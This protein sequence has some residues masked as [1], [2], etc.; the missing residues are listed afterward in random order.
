M[1]I[2]IE[3]FLNNKK[4]SSSTTEVVEEEKKYGKIYLVKVATGLGKTKEIEAADVPLIACPTNDLKRELYDRRVASGKEVVMTPDSVKFSDERLDEKVQILYILDDY[5]AVRHIIQSI[6]KYGAYEHYRVTTDDRESCILY[7]DQNKQIK[8]NK[9]KTIITTHKRVMNGS[10]GHRVVIFDED[11]TPTLIDESSFFLQDLEKLEGTLFEEYGKSLKKH[12]Q[13]KR[14]SVINK[15]NLDTRIHIHRLG[16]KFKDI[17]DDLK[18]HLIEKSEISLLKFLLKGQDFY[19]SKDFNN[20]TNVKFV[21]DDFSDINLERTVIVLSATVNKH[22]YRK[23]HGEDKVISEDITRIHLTGKIIQDTRRSYSKNT[24]KHH[25]RKGDVVLDKLLREISKSGNPIISHKLFVKNFLMDYNFDSENTKVYFGNC[26]GYD[27]YTNRDLTVLGT[28]HK[29]P[30]IFEKF[31]MSKDRIIDIK[32]SDR[33]VEWR[34]FRFRFM[35]Y[36]DVDLYNLQMDAIESDLIQ[37]VGR[38]R[39]LRNDVTVKVYSNFPLYIAT[40]FITPKK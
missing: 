6:S 24:M 40:D 2:N 27:E 11:P 4:P 35:A 38:A 31:I 18:N 1:S 37:A 34:E 23:V 30:K 16:N 13:S 14:M 10:F 36:E 3:D 7:L 32:I 5:K 39:A 28:P 33:V 19:T 8:E 22:L 17:S 25:L 15:D 21:I 26:S 12:L 29:P 9:D 20:K